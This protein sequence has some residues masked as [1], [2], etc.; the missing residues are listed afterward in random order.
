MVAFLGGGR[1]EARETGRVGAFLNA[2]VGLSAGSYLAAHVFAG[3]PLPDVP[4]LAQHAKA[5]ISQAAI[6]DLGPRAAGHQP[7]Q[8]WSIFWEGGGPGV[9]VAWAKNLLRLAG[10]PLSA[11]NVQFIYD[12]EFNEGR[13]AGRPSGCGGGLYNP[14]NQ[15]PVP[16]RPELTSTGQQYGGGA[17]DYVSWAAGLA[18]SVAYLHMGY[19]AGILA[20]LQRSDYHAAMVALW[21]SPWAGSHYGY[22]ANWR[23]APAGT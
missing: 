9:A 14:L 4:A 10:L 22:G 5:G 17:A 11:A 6:G 13:C 20:G 21:N 19:Y 3:A 23:T 8:P 7:G 18:G 2:A 1:R 16:G 15:G 12:W